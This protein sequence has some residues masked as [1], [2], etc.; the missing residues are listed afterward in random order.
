M[1]VVVHLSD[2]HF[3][4]VDHALLAPLARR[5]RAVQPHLVV[6]SGDLTQRAKSA[7]FRDAR[8]FL[9][10]LPGTLLVV[11]GNHDVPFYNLFQRFFQPLAK[12]RRYISQEPEPVFVDDELAVVGMNS[13]RSAAFKGGRINALQIE[14]VRERLCRLDDRITKIVVTH[15]P[16]DLVGRARQAMAMFAS[17]GAD[18]LL[19]GHLHASHTGG[20]TALVVQAGTATSLRGR[21]EA[22][23]FNVLHIERPQ[24]RIERYGWSG[25]DFM[26]CA[27]EAFTRTPGGWQRA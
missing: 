26:V 14:R 4:R 27:S 20:T 24:V 25:A 6:V 2:L 3:G 13:A 17:C 23:S 19:A 8:R 21:G 12:Y 16:F 9:D 18:L 10:T 11:P 22:N 5:V 1:R 15:H 7:E